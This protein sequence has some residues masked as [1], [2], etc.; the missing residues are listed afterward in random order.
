M[1]ARLEVRSDYVLVTFTGP[2]SPPTVHQAIRETI[3]AAA[4]SGLNLILADWSGVEGMATT[5]QRLE[6]AE[7]GIAHLQGRTWEQPL[8]VAIVGP[9]PLV[10]GLMAAVA[11]NRGVNTRTFPDQQQALDW[12]GIATS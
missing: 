7:I 6:N 8:K 1:E 10:N 2:L 11:S 9:F 4:A 12:L 3:D 5:G